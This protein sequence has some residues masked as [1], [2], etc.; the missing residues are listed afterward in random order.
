[1]NTNP[2]AKSVLCY[3]DSNTNGTKPDR[4]GR[5]KP[6]ERWTGVLQNSLG[7]NYYVIE[8]GLGGRTTDLEHFNPAKPNRNGLKYFKPCID[9]HMPLDYI[10]IMLGT[11]DFK[12]VYKRSAREVA[13]V[14]QNYPEYVKS[15][16]KARN[17]KTPKIVMVSPAYMDENASKFVESMPTQGIYDE[18]SAQKTRELAEPLKIIAEKSGCIFYDA[19]KVAKTGEDGCHL[20]KDSH[21]KLGKELA[22]IIQDN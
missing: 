11:N 17:L 19:G 14:L 22:K 20:D 4:S 13:N 7:D 1:M 6:A 10:I 9:S 16:C 18:K 5:F 2:S 8:E 15:Y 3:G 12:T 21:T